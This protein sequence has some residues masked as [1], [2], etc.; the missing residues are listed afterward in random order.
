MPLVLHLDSADAALLQSAPRRVEVGER[1]TIGRGPDN[2]LVLPDPN[3]HLSKNHCVIAFDGRG[4]TVTDTS[5]NGVF[6]DN[7]AE[8]LPRDVPTPLRDGSVL[9]LGAYAI[10]VAAVVPPAAGAALL[11]SAPH[12]APHAD[13]PLF[14][15]PF[16]APPAAASHGGA[17]PGDDELFGLAPQ[18]S[19]PT[20]ARPLAAAGP[21]EDPFGLAPARAGPAPLIPD[22]VDLFGDSE[23]GEPWHGPSQPDNAPADQ[24]FFAP[25]KV[26]AETI[27]EDWDA[28]G[29]LGLP[30]TP[31]APVPSP[32]A[33]PPPAFRPAAAAA[34]EIGAA[35]GGD[36]QA[37]AAFLAA[38]GLAGT[39]L[40]AAE[41]AALMRLVGETIAV[42]VKGLTEIL[43]ARSSTKQ[44]FRIERTT[45]GA[46]GN[47]PL[48]FSAGLDEALRVMLL[49]RTPGFLTAR[50]AVEEA[51]EDVKSHQLAV[52]AGMQVAL[53]TVIAR[54]DP[55]KLEERLEK[56]SLIEG[57]L[58]A[59]RKARY[60]EL[61][62][63]L[64]KEI[65]AELQDDFQSLFGAEFARAYKAQIEKL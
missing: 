27:P 11:S 23:E 8:R 1:L 33:A 14:G 13:D 9:H 15:D 42:T 61:F 2:D 47:N 22:D 21:A 37:I 44:E 31:A 32:A 46:M 19:P 55:A 59:A 17:L 24:V 65:A 63:A 62:R 5:T 57:I 48:K 30:R 16:A 41:K 52:L 34:P 49:G 64:Y 56:S 36:A 6:L 18:A 43:A 58:P 7:D 53:Q 3:R 45:L 26:V 10:T 35:P 40:D 50:Q 4:Y 51:L 29:D 38:V 12:P 60:W 25:P 54:F 20:P 39:A 28:L